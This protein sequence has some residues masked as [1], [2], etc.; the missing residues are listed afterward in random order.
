MHVCKSSKEHQLQTIAESERFP[1]ARK[2]FLRLLVFGSLQKLDS[3]A[4]HV[5]TSYRMRQKNK[6]KLKL[7]IIFLMTKVLCEAEKTW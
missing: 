4:K 5:C 6:I 2:C 3:T 1:H 7:K